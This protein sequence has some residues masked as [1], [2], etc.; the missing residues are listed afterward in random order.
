MCYIYDVHC[1][2]TNDRI[3]CNIGTV[4]ANNLRVEGLI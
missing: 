2:M 3:K 1:D 4:F